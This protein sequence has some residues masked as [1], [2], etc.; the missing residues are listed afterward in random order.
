MATWPGGIGD[1]TRA[2]GF[3]R[4]LKDLSAIEHGSRCPQMPP[5][6]SN[7]TLPAPMLGLRQRPGQALTLPSCH[8]CQGAIFQ[9]RVFTPF[10][11]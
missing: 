6:L 9:R 4:W 10:A 8:Q 2:W 5:H 11:S 3:H 7:Y 1:R